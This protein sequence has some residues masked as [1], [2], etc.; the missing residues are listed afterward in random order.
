MKRREFSAAAA[1]WGLAGLGLPGLAQA[2]HRQ[3][4]EGEYKALGRPAP[5][6]APAGK[7]EVVEFFWYS[8]PHC[9]AFE[10]QLEAW[11]QKLP[12]DV[13]LR[14]VPV[15]F[16]EDFVPQQR[17]FFALEA[18]NRLDLHGKVFNAIHQDRQPLSRPEA[19]GAWAEQQGLERARFDE[20]Y[21]SEATTAKVRQAIALQD[22]Y[23]VEGVPA[24]GIAG[25]Y[26]TDGSL[27]GNMVRALQITDFLLA[28]ARKSR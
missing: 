1:A 2:Q 8:C 6:A 3:P 25:R 23:Q 9:N 19:I 28:Q 7:V 14:R 16:R 15:A 13:V 10:P 24:L 27:A 11:V 22:A 5:T 4:Q 21:R 26:Y 12:A 20:A 18:I 17:L